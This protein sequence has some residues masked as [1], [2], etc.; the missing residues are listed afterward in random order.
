MSNF[1][2]KK[3]SI[4]NQKFIL[5]FLNKSSLLFEI[6]ILTRLTGKRLVV[7]ESAKV[8]RICPFQKRNSLCHHSRTVLLAF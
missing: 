2:Q 8:L 3:L 6:L 5:I 1:Y 7:L 4:M